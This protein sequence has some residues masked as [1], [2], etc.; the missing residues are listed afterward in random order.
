MANKKTT[1]SE[2]DIST[3]QPMA[4]APYEPPKEEEKLTGKSKLDPIKVKMGVITATRS[5]CHEIIF[6]RFIETEEGFEADILLKNL[7]KVFGPRGGSR[8][9]LPNVKLTTEDPKELETLLYALS[10]GL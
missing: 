4:V 7:Q 1:K 3:A 2:P 8:L 10:Q 5:L 6:R 9:L